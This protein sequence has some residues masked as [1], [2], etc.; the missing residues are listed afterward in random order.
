MRFLLVCALF[1]HTLF[2]G[3]LLKEELYQDSNQIDLLLSF[4]TPFSGT[5][6]KQIEKDGTIT[7][8]LSNTDLKE[9]F[10]KSLQQSFLESIRLHAQSNHTTAIQLK[11]SQGNLSVKAIKT[12]GG[13]KLRLRITPIQRSSQQESSGMIA[14]NTVAHPSK[15]LHTLDEQSR[16]PGWRYWSVLG[17][18][19]LL[20]L[21]LWRIKKKGIP[22]FLQNRWLFPSAY[23]PQK[24]TYEATIRYQKPLD[25]HNRLLLLEFGDRQYLM[26]IGNTNLLLDTFNTQ[27]QEPNED[28][29]NTFSHLL[30]ASQEEL[31]A[32]LQENHSEG[33]EALKTHANREK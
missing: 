19:F 21:I 7:I 2:A 5:I 30:N 10:Q 25:P 4:D 24:S 31:E 11:P 22:S 26:V 18:L 9:P 15:P 23:S 27:K 13:L 32:F 16:L 1:T 29:S 12:S 14:L 28:D 33:H 20:L 6:S 3:L 17:V 8:V